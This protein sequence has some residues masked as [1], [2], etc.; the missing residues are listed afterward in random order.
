MANGA[1]FS[2]LCLMS[3]GLGVVT[4]TVAL[5]ELDVMGVVPAMAWAVAVFVTKPVL[6]SADVVV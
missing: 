2:E 1:V 5:A 4:V 3:Q 6:T